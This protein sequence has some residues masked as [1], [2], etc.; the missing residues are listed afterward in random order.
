MKKIM[1][2][3]VVIG[4]LL[5]SSFPVFVSGEDQSSNDNISMSY[6]FGTPTISDVYIDD[7]RYDRIT[8]EETSNGGEPGEPSLPVKGVSILIPQGNVVS[9]IMV[10]PSEMIC[11]GSGYLVE[12]A[13]Q[14]ILIS[15]ISSAQSSTPN[16][17]V[18]SSEERFPGRLF[19]EVGTYSC[20][21]Y[22]I[23]VLKLHPVQ[24]MPASGELFYYSDLSISVETVADGVVSSLYRGLEKDEQNLMT[25]VDNYE[26]VSS[27]AVQSE[28]NPSIDEYDLLIIT[29]EA[30]KDGF[31]PLKQAH[32]DDGLNTLIYTV[33]DIYNGFSGAD[34]AEKIR[35]FIT[36][37]YHVYGIEYVLLGG[38]HEI[39]PS[40]YLYTWTIF[41]LVISDI[42]YA[43]LD[44]DW[45]GKPELPLPSHKDLSISDPGVNG[46]SD[47][48]FFD[49]VV[50]TTEYIVGDSSMRFDGDPDYSG[51]NR[52]SLF[53]TLDSPLNIKD[54]NWVRF[55][56]NVS[57]PGL[58]S[59]LA[60][61]LH[62][63][64]GLKITIPPFSHWTYSFSSGSWLTR[65]VRKENCYEF[66]TI[67]GYRF[68]F[69]FKK[70]V[71]IEFEIDLGDD[72][73]GDDYIRLDG[74]YFSKFSDPI[75]GEPGEEDYSAEVFVGRACA[76]NLE[77]VQNFTSKTIAYMNTDDDEEYLKKVSVVGEYLGFPLVCKWGGN[78]MDDLIGKC[79]KHGY[80]TQ[81][82]PSNK[83][84][85][86][87][88]YDKFWKENGWPDPRDNDGGGWPKE[89]IINRINNDVHIINH[90]GHGV[91]VR[92]MK[93]YKADMDSLTNEKYCFIYSQSC[94]SGNFGYPHTDCIAEHLTVKTEHGAFAGIWNSHYG[95]GPLIWKT[96]TTDGISQR[97]NREFWDAVF[98]EDIKEIGRANQDS[99]EDNLW[100]IDEMGMEFSY[101]VI[102]L[103]GDPAVKFKYLDSSL[104][105]LES[106]SS[107]ENIVYQESTTTGTEI[108]EQSQG[109]QSSPSNS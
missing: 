99:K 70:I 20:R 7:T 17:A 42:Y 85:I 94:L 33:E 35:N 67:P 4:C 93:L 3:I 54:K 61:V 74:I 9:N 1:I 28:S 109:T 53:L 59:H 49:P 30:L 48:A 26:M 62:D 6:Y 43:G 32:E 38:D 40:R 41:P 106:Q 87:K 89:E 39:V 8:I 64:K 72:V 23:L 79:K 105:S 88:L 90:L 24:Y 81:G 29:S 15:D 27:Y 47:G 63:S 104:V 46:Y 21:G 25:S 92:N 50:D 98:N 34:K 37:A 58:I 56:I 18:Y 2:S 36:F 44:G 73:T 45:N 78:F 10:T 97:Y 80:T 75:L 66:V 108:I 65:I 82:F 102:T 19:T 95:A 16:E 68:L 11:L 107:Q 83:F 96:Y 31:E 100:R 22:E 69:N 5:L 55:S 52:A 14:P 60:I 12:P 76:D 86:D 84:S 51:W 13:T 103:F 77:D 71:K 57:R 101:K 91:E